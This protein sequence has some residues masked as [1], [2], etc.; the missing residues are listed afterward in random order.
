ML[1]EVQK[2]FLLEVDEDKKT[3]LVEVDEEEKKEV[4]MDG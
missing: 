2:Q 3:V 4:K 1:A